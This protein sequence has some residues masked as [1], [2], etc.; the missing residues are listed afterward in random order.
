[1]PRIE[2]PANEVAAA[3]LQACGGKQRGGQKA[4]RY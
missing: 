4:A 1:M 2:Q 3:S